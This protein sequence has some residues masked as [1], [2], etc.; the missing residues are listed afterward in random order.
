MKAD[1]ED[2]PIRV[3]SGKKHRPLLFALVLVIGTVGLGNLTIGL[4]TGTVNSMEQADQAKRAIQQNKP[5]A[6]MADNP[7]R[8]IVEAV[9][10][11][12]LDQVNRMLGITDD[13]VSESTANIEWGKPEQQPQTDRQTVF[14]DATYTPATTVNTVRMPRQRPQPQPTPQTQTRQQPYV[15]V[16]KETR[17]SCGFFKPGSLECRRTRAQIYKNHSRACLQS[18]DSQSISCRLAKSY[19]PTR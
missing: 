6:Q 10:D 11:P 19:E 2:A 1:W 13:Y 18:G 7:Y 8:P 3:L 4:L 12:Y 14:S 17:D 9:E 5:S 15:T 16:V